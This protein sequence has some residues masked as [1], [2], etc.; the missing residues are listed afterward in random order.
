MDDR[1][2]VDTIN[3]VRD[4]Q[5]RRALRALLRGEGR[6]QMFN[7][8]L[9]AALGRQARETQREGTVM[10]PARWMARKSG[11]LVG[12]AMRKLEARADEAE[13]ETKQ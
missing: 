4:A 3:S 6:T 5:E 10:R 13:Q 7:N 8:A 11:G 12:R 1:Q 2:I 9:V